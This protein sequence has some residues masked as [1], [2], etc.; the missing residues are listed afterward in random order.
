[1]TIF[2]TDGDIDVF[3][4]SAL[5]ASGD[6]APLFAVVAAGSDP[7]TTTRIPLNFNAFTG[8]IFDISAD[9]ITYTEI[10][11][12]LGGGFA[13]QTQSGTVVLPT[14]EIEIAWFDNFTDE[15]NTPDWHTATTWEP[16]GDDAVT[17]VFNPH[18]GA[19]QAGLIVS[20]VG[21]F[22]LPPQDITIDTVTVAEEVAV[23]AIPIPP[24]LW[25]FG[26]ALIGMVG[27]ARR[28][29]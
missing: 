2:P 5:L 6:P 29:K 4:I 11:P 26:S 25:L 14:P 12:E 17:L 27:V 1:M 18:E 22:E 19:N 7:N 21:T 3:N 8:Q 10:A 16:I 15:G 23:S 28:S 13:F 24:A 20:D 9:Q